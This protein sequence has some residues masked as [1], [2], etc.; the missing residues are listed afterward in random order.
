MCKTPKSRIAKV[1]IIVS[2]ED[3]DSN[4]EASDYVY[5]AQRVDLENDERFAAAH[6]EFLINDS[7][8]I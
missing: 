2:D 3:D 5:T 1:K 7:D 4:G 6:M 8:Y